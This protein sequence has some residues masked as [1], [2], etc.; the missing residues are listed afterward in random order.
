MKHIKCYCDASFDPVSKIAVIGWKI[1]DGDIQ[2]FLCKNTNNSR[3]EIIGLI[4][5]ISLL[6]PTNEYIIFTDCES[7]IRRLSNKEILI[8]KDFKN[9]AGMPL[10]NVDLYK[11]L[12]EIIPNNIIIKHINGHMPIKLMADENII[13]STVDKFVRK[14]LR[15]ALLKI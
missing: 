7:I 12:F 2:T 3:A 8:N 9:K 1:G 14:L 10:S 13:F 11:K 15:S 6:N 4:N 5:L